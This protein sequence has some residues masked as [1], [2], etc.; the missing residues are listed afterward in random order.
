[1]Y[2]LQYLCLPESANIRQWTRNSEN[3]AYLLRSMQRNR[4]T[5]VWVTFGQKCKRIFYS[6]RHY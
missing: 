1:M 6:C 5:A 3:M 2:A 4:A